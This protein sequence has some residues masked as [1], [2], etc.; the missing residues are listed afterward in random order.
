MN[1]QTSSYMALLFVTSLVLL[2]W[3]S[4]NRDTDGTEETKPMDNTPDFFMS[5]FSIRDYTE[6][7]KLKYS[8]KAAHLEHY[9]V[10][11]TAKV[12]NPLIT[13]YREENQAPWYA[14]SKVGLVDGEGKVLTL[15]EQVR[16]YNDKDKNTQL[17]VSME[18]LVINIEEELAY[19]DE[20]VVLNSAQGQLQ[21]VGLEAD[22]VS[23]RLQLKS[24]VKGFH[25]PLSF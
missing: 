1:A 22:L 25:E 15:T 17:H 11:D 8:I 24:Q 3:Y 20:K 19:T 12:Q 21:A 18:K 23:N 16:L 10:D 5:D 7:G 13:I 14:E 6:Q 9:P 2:F 4:S